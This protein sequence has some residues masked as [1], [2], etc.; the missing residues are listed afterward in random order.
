MLLVGYCCG[1][2]SER[3]LCEEVHLILACRWF[4]RLGL[5]GDVPGHSTFSKNRHGRLPRERKPTSLR[6]VSGP[7]SLFLAR[8]RV[9]RCEG[10]EGGEGIGEVLVVVCKATASTEPRESALDH[11]ATRQHDVNLPMADLDRSYPDRSSRRYATRGN[12]RAGARRRVVR[13]RR[14]WRWD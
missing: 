1:I 9:S 10:V 3:R 13:A 14:W 12:C 6:N 7:R 11:P 5:D 8:T 2:R 4:C